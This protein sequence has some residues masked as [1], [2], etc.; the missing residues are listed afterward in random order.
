MLLWARNMKQT[1]IQ[2]LENIEPDLAVLM[3]WLR[4]P[5][6]NLVS[7]RRGLLRSSISPPMLSHQAEAVR[8]IHVKVQS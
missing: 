4:P 8:V 7:H 5:T 6:S 1:T 3:S 2:V